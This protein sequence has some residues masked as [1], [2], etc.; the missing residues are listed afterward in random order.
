[1]DQYNTQIQDIAPSLGLNFAN[2]A[3][4]LS[5]NLLW[6]VLGLLAIILGATTVVLYYHWMRYGFGDR[7]VIFAQVLYTVVLISGFAVMIGSV[8]YYG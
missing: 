8:N 5:D 6:G 1:M 4:K 2:L 3:A 7:M